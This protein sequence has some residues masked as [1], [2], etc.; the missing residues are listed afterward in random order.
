MTSLRSSL[1][2]AKNAV[3]SSPPDAEPA[4]STDSSMLHS[5]LQVESMRIQALESEVRETKKRHDELLHER[6]ELLRRARPIESFDNIKASTG[7]AHHLQG[8]R[9][10]VQSIRQRDLWIEAQQA[11]LGEFRSG[12]KQ[13]KDGLQ[14][15]LDLFHSL[16]IDS[17]TSIE[18]GAVKNRTGIELKVLLEQS[19]AALE[20][21]TTEIQ[22]PFPKGEIRAPDSIDGICSSFLSMKNRIEEIADHARV[23]AMNA[24]LLKDRPAEPDALNSLDVEMTNVS[25]GLRE[26]ANFSGSIAPNL[27]KTRQQV[28]DIALDVEGRSHILLDQQSK[29]E[30]RIAQLSTILLDG[31]HRL[32]R[33]TKNDVDSE[34]KLRFELERI[35]SAVHDTTEALTNACSVAH[36]LDLTIERMVEVSKIATSHAEPVKMPLEAF[37]N[38]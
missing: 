28:E 23:A 25:A 24:R 34:V 9:E 33:I 6:V 35:E 36:S 37:A 32:E 38:D 26:L 19:A 16:D 1:H 31:Q 15:C 4:Q 3:P 18:E 12:L 13:V 30:Q 14:R 20:K 2:E 10:A 21:A 7:S 8:G 11:S 29:F 22:T 27:D 17:L 5:R